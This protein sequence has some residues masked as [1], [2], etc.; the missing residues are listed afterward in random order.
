MIV[1]CLRRAKETNLGP[2][3][4][5]CGDI[6]IKKVVEDAGGVAVMTDPGHQSGSDRVYEALCDV[7]PHETHDCV[8][9]FQGYQKQFWD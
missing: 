7:D 9:N 3:V 2:V 4:V 6:E 8:I 5:A 1:Q